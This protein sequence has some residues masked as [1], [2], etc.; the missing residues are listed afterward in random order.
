MDGAETG[1]EV[2]VLPSH[3]FGSIASGGSL[4]EGSDGG[5]GWAGTDEW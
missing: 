5:V 4:S 2:M 1:G 3:T